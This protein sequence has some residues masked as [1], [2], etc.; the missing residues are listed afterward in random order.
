MLSNQLNFAHSHSKSLSLI[1]VP[2]S[3]SVNEALGLRIHLVQS[4][5][6]KTTRI[7]SPIW[8]AS[9]HLI[10]EW[11]MHLMSRNFRLLLVLYRVLLML[12]AWHRRRRMP[13]RRRPRSI[14]H[15]APTTKRRNS[16]ITRRPPIVRLGVPRLRIICLPLPLLLWN[17]RVRSRLRLRKRK[18]LIEARRRVFRLSRP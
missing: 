3:K 12:R 16:R 6:P 9:P 4:S 15:G 5:F 13:N 14:P 8:P 17:R 18:V 10:R 11:R 7:Q 2:G 1:P